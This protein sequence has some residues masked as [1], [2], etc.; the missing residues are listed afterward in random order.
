[1]S[2][3]DDIEQIAEDVVR[4][5]RAGDQNAHALIVTCRKA[6]NAGSERAQ[7]VIKAIVAYCTANPVSSK[8]QE[9]DS[10]GSLLLPLPKPAIIGL[11]QLKG[12][13]QWTPYDV[14]EETK[15]V[16]TGAALC[17]LPIDRHTNEVA[18]VILASGAPLTVQRIEAI[19]SGLPNEQLQK[20]FKLMVCGSSPPRGLPPGAMR[21]VFAGHI[22]GKARCLQLAR[23]PGNPIAPYD[24]DMGT[25]LD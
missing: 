25:E 8:V 7:A 16:C 19:G 14:D 12:V 5:D 22:V 11:S 17:R 2:N 13:L 4:R 21:V 18:C 6:A 9:F 15:L 23:K 1:M 20:L 10:R 3:Q 24:A